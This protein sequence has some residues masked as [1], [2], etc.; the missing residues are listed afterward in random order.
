MKQ[1]LRGLGQINHRFD[2][3]L[4]AGRRSW[5]CKHVFENGGR[6]AKDTFV[7]LEAYKIVGPYSYV[8]VPTIKW[9]TKVSR[10]TTGWL[11]FNSFAQIIEK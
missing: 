7:D 4:S 6:N 3:P 11:R 8:R 10:L 1:R 5:G 2:L 9:C